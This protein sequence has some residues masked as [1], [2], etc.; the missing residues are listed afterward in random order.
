MR[1]QRS[2]VLSRIWPRINA[3]LDLLLRVRALDEL[4]LWY[5]GAIA[6]RDLNHMRMFG[7]HRLFLVDCTDA[8][9]G[10]QKRRGGEESTDSRE[11]Q[12]AFCRLAISAETKT[13]PPF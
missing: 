8:C 4:C 9:P 12:T 3:D 5:R 10:V 2:G 11:Q 6:P 7:R 1:R 13:E